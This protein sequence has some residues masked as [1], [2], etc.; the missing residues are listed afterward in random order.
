[1]NRNQQSFRTHGNHQALVGC[2]F[3]DVDVAVLWMFD[4]HG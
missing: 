1:M 3:G 2:L 4:M